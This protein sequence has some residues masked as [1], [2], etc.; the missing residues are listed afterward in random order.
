MP[1]MKFRL[2]LLLA[3]LAPFSKTLAQGWLWSQSGGGA[4]AS[5]TQSIATDKWGNVYVAGIFAGDTVVFGNT[6]VMN[7]GDQNIFLIKYG[8]SGNQIWVKRFGGFYTDG[9]GGIALDT[10]G[11]IYMA[12]YFSSAF[13]KFGS[14]ILPNYYQSVIEVGGNTSD[15]FVAKLDSGGNGV[16]AQRFGG[17]GSEMATCITVGYHGEVA[18]AGNFSS[19]TVV[20]GTNNILCTGAYDMF[21]IKYDASGNALWL[22]TAG[23]PNAEGASS[24]ATDTSG[25]IYVAGNFTSPN[26]A[27]GGTTVHNSGSG[28][29]D[30]FLAKY[31]ADAYPL[32]ARAIG[33][34]NDDFATSL[35]STANG[36]LFLA[37][38]NGSPQIEIG[39]DTFYNTTGFGNMVL[40]SFNTAGNLLW[41]KAGAHNENIAP[42]CIT[43]D[44][45]GN[46]LMAGYFTS[47][48]ATFGTSL[49]SNQGSTGYG[50]LFLSKFT[51]SGTPIWAAN[52]GGLNDELAN[53]VATNIHGDIFVGGYFTDQQ[54]YFG[55]ISDTSQNAGVNDMFISKF[56]EAKMAVPTIAN[57][58]LQINVYP[59]PVVYNSVEVDLGKG[60]YNLL[61]IYDCLGKQV[62][63]KQIGLLDK[64]KHIDL[65]ILPSG[66]YFIKAFGQDG[67]NGSCSFTK[68]K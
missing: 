15:A 26:L 57:Q 25:N 63:T 54:M 9:V 32:W 39:T 6:P 8:P 23:G 61:I 37:G 52:A 30:M 31:R 12:G 21:A 60:G 38:T 48:N 24:I 5:T 20:F 33:G 18:A 29:N 43:L 44:S 45:T 56:N 4:A 41:A 35:V 17:P 28:T 64:T 46:I 59:N 49:L 14:I 3:L 53:T 50:D 42:Q 62:I 40:A 13:I 68:T 47:A 66:T 58:V 16:W 19:D 1:L 51:Q 27:F 55:L 2:V 65:S 34:T 11:N 22:V 7:A 36:N 10:L 67:A